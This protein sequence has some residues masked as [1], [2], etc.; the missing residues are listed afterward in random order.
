MAMLGCLVAGP[1]SAQVFTMGD[2]YIVQDPSGAITNLTSMMNM[3]IFP[4]P[5]EQFCRAAFNAIRA[6]G[7][8]DD[9]DGIFAFSTADNTITDIGD[10]WQGTPVRSDAQGI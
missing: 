9:F 10:V 8:P 1:A 4:S 3:T 6:G 7:A 2:L 5:Q